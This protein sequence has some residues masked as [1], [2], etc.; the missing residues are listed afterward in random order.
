MA[1]PESGPSWALQFQWKAVFHQARLLDGWGARTP[2][3]RYAAI[4][5]MIHAQE[6]SDKIDA[7]I[8]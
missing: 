6:L 1:K 3:T 8:E 4:G 2:R 7:C 5:T